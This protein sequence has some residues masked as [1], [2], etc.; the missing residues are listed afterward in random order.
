MYLQLAGINHKTAAVDFREQTAFVSEQ[1]PE[2]LVELGQ[3]T[4]ATEMVVLSTC[5]RTEIYSS[6]ADAATLM[7]WWAQ[8]RN[9]DPRLL[10]QHCYFMQ[11]SDAIRHLI[12]VC[13]G[14]DSM[15]L[16][17]SQIFG[18]TKNAFGVAK[19]QKC[20]FRLSHIFEQSF[21]IAKLVRTNTG[22][23]TNQH[24]PVTAILHLM[25][26]LFDQPQN[27]SAMLLGAGEMT[28][29]VGRGLTRVPLQ[30][31]II[32][33]RNL[34]RAAALAG[35]LGTEY[36]DFSRLKEE[37]SRVDTLI[38][39]ASSQVNLIGMELLK[40]C[41]TARR[42]PLLIVDLAVP[43]NVDSK[44]NQLNGVY[45]YDIDNLQELMA[46]SATIRQTEIETANKLITAGVNKMN[47]L[48]DEKAAAK[49][50]S[51]YRQRA[52]QLR[53]QTLVEFKNRSLPDQTADEQLAE[54]ARMLTN[55]LIH[56]PCVGMRS[57]AAQ[58]RDDMLDYAETLLNL[59]DSANDND[60]CTH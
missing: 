55:R 36:G 24:T 33:N 10:R 54:L 4:T 23:G 3:K 26:K 57:A 15:I 32:V 58:Q 6:G 45:L 9:I 25:H 47:T 11:D 56:D 59:P 12:E 34:S 2:V 46:D 7:N 20:V 17:E 21:R 1:I 50:I 51:S 40:N 60:D 5:N 30:R 37:L 19:Q 48:W 35:S 22:I 49:L 38:T 16:G 14:L 41:L 8:N 27:T 43:R 42:K 29:L 39:C 31:T 53:D 28:E 44:A 13:C 52:L 18:Q